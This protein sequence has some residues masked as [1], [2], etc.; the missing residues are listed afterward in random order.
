MKKNIILLAGLLI[1]IASYSQVSIG[2]ALPNASANLDITAIDINGNT[3]GLLIPRLNLVSTTDAATISNGNINS[4]LVYNEATQADVT[5]GFYYWYVNKWERIANTDNI[6]QTN[7]T[8]LFDP[9][10]SSLSYTNEQGNNPS[11]DLN[12]L[13]IEPWQVELTSI[14]ATSNT[15]NIYQMGDVGI[16]TN[17]ILAGSALDVRGAIRGGTLNAGVVGTNSAAFGTNN[18]VSGTNS[19]ATGN[20][21]NVSGNISGA[22]GT[23]NLV[24]TNN[25]MAIGI[26]N[27]VNA[28]KSFTVGE[29]NVLTGI[30]AS[31][32]GRENIVDGEN[33]VAHGVDNQSLADFTYTLGVGNISGAMGSMVFGRYNA[34]TGGN[35]NT[36]ISP[37]DPYFQLANGT[38]VVDRSNIITVL[39]NGKTG[40]GNMN[41]P[42]ATVHI[43]KTGTDLTPAIIEGCQVYADNAAA[44]TAGIPVGGLYRTA[45]G[46]LMVRY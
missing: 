26:D 17:D 12:P 46:I 23:N 28:E 11:I 5:P 15:Q 35:P 38:S 9:T 29:G 44:T 7:T 20:N 39:K 27:V 25:S 42:Q 8:L 41:T 14:K 21:N 22:I 32:M 33:A 3:R 13:K 40:F 16:G 30:Y 2:T 4:L 6:I 18:R 45:T 24:N 37:L 31:A 1:S 43:L 36:F 10:T 19:S 34:L